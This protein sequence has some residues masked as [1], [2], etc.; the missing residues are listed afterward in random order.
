MS[1]RQSR[2]AGNRARV[3]GGPPLEPALLADLAR[4]RP[5]LAD[6]ALAVG[7]ELAISHPTGHGSTTRSLLLFGGPI[8]YI[9]TQAWWYHASTGQAWGTRLLARLALALAGA[10]TLR[11]PP[12]ASVVILDLRPRRPRHHPAEGEPPGP[13]GNDRRNAHLK[14][15][16]EGP[17]GSG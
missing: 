3:V 1:T 6:L 5:L 9:V 7:A 17:A 13:H 2:T 11:L 4:A 8:L 10:V 12:L 15:V 14:G 16:A